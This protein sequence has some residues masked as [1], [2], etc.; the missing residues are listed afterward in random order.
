LNADDLA[1]S[2]ADLMIHLAKKNGFADNYNRM[3]ERII[4]DARQGKFGRYTLEK[5]E[6]ENDA[7]A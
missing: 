4:F 2:D 3:A 5:P 6:A 1:L 7:N